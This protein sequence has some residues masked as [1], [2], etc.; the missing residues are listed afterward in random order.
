MRIATLK[1]FKLTLLAAIATAGMLAMSP[2]GSVL[3]FET[4]TIVKNKIKGCM[5]ST[6]DTIHIYEEFG[7]PRECKKWCD[8]L[9]NIGIGGDCCGWGA[10][11]INVVTSESSAL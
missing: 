11:V 8:V 6:G 2:S 3:A 10:C 4:T 5:L 7:N 1:Q 9:N